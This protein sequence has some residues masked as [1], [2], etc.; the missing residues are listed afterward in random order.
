MISRRRLI[1]ST[2]ALVATSAVVSACGGGGTTS[3]PGSSASGSAGDVNPGGIVNLELQIPFEWLDP[4]Q[5]Y[6]NDSSSFAR[7]IYRTLMGW[8]EDP[9]KGTYELVPDLASAA[10]TNSNGGK[11]WTFKL[12]PGIKY[13]DGSPVTANDIKYGVERSMDPA[14]SNGPQYAKQYLIGADK[15]TGPA[16]GPLASIV[17]PDDQTITF[18]LKQPVGFWD[19]L[20]TLYTFTPV[21]RA[22]D[23]GRSYDLNPVTMGPYKFQSYNKQSRIVLVKDTN[24]SKDTDPLRS[25]N[26]QQVITTMGLDQARE[27]SDLISDTNGGTNVMFQGDLAPA[28]INKVNQE[29]LKS[30]TL[31]ATTIF[32]Q[33]LAVQQKN[34]AL[35]KVEVRQ[36]IVYALNP[37]ASIQAI[38]GPLIREPIQSFAP[39]TLKGF[40][41]VKDTYDI[42]DE[43][44]PDKAKQLLQQAG[45]S[46]L[47]LTY[48]FSNT[49]IQAQVA[50]TIVS[51]LARAGITVVPK[52]IESGAYYKTV[53]TQSNS[54]DL[55]AGGW[56]YDIPDGATIFPP[57]FQGGA[58]LYDG[59]SNLS[60]LDDP[61]VNKLIDQALAKPT[62]AEALPIWQQIDK[63]IIDQALVI[64]R[65]VYKVA[66]IMGSKVKGAYI[67]PVLGTV[68][69]TNAY[70]SKT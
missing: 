5:V 38:G 37:K 45:V 56:G 54:Y 24:W 23:T 62:T 29:P 40:E 2:G 26:F 4:Q 49:P 30:R 31:F 32:I 48:A 63:Y 28:D 12:K 15:Y 6:V 43:G 66:P 64:P 35:K 14:I 70:I 3:T 1:T 21:P 22:K 16:K 52:P 53:S 25:Q 27:D 55:A 33:Y 20:T 34:P 57:I 19:Q 18:N 13:S 67:S 50:Q 46:N 58:N 44:K 36:A 42:G 17:V 68:D 60:K 47:T 51:A 69:V 10:P 65:F 59:T 9:A 61:M 7:M 41:D 39:P 8:K 11:T